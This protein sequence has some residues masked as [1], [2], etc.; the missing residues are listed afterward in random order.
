MLYERVP[1][2]QKGSSPAGDQAVEQAPQGS[3]YSL[4]C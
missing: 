3:G 2:T 1:V 4:R